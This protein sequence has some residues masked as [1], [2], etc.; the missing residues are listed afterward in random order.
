MQYKIGWLLMLAAALMIPSLV[1]S[2]STSAAHQ[3]LQAKLAE[4]AKAPVD[5]SYISPGNRHKMQINDKAYAQEL[6]KQGARLVAEYEGSTV[7][8]VDTPTANQLKQSGRGENRDNFNLVML[9]AGYIDTSTPQGQ[10]LS[11][12]SVGETTE[13][14]HMRLVQ[15]TS[16]V[17]PEWYDAMVNAGLEVVTYM[18]SNAYLVFGDNGAMNRFNRFAQRSGAVQAAYSRTPTSARSQETAQPMH[19]LM[20]PASA[21]ALHPASTSSRSDSSGIRHPQEPATPARQLQVRR[22]SCVSASSTPALLRQALR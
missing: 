13:G 8:E 20:Q 4:D 16:A 21:A 3:D 2:I 10:E 5:D 17:K 22:P 18:P 9:N 11:L 15:F 14:P 6:R 19:V 12:Q 7:V 1:W